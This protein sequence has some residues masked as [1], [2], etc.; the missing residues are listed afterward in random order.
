MSGGSRK[1]FKPKNRDEAMLESVGIDRLAN[2]VIPIASTAA[3][4]TARRDEPVGALLQAVPG[5]IANKSVPISEG[6]GCVTKLQSGA[7][8]APVAVSVDGTRQGGDG[9]VFNPAAQLMGC[10]SDGVAAKVSDIAGKFATLSDAYLKAAGSVEKKVVDA[11]PGSR[12]NPINLWGGTGDGIMST[13][14]LAEYICTEMACPTTEKAYRA[15]AA[16][17]PCHGGNT[18]FHKMPIVAGRDVVFGFEGKL[19]AVRVCA[20]SWR[21]D[22]SCGFDPTSYQGMHAASFEWGGAFVGDRV[23]LMWESKFERGM[24]VNF[25]ACPMVSQ[26]KASETE[27]E[28][29]GQPFVFDQEEAGRQSTDHTFEGVVV[30]AFL[31]DGTSKWSHVNDRCKKLLDHRQ[32]LVKD[33]REGRDF[34]EG[35]V[36]GLSMD[37]FITDPHCIDEEVLLCALLAVVALGRE[38]SEALEK[39]A[40]PPS[41]KAASKRSTNVSKPVLPFVQLKAADVVAVVRRSRV[42]PRTCSCNAL[43]CPSASN[44][45]YALVVNR[46]WG[47]DGRPSR[48]LYVVSGLAAAIEKIGQRC[49][50]LDS[51]SGCSFGTRAERGPNVSEVL[52]LPGSKDTA[53]I[54]GN[55]SRVEVVVVEDSAVFE[56]DIRAGDRYSCLCERLREECRKGRPMTGKLGAKFELLPFFI[57]AIILYWDGFNHDQDTCASAEGVYFLPQSFPSTMRATYVCIRILGLGPS[58]SNIVHTIKVVLDEVLNLVEH[59]LLVRLPDG[60]KMMVFVLLTGCVADSPALSSA[61]DGGGHSSLSP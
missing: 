8:A 51:A 7:E 12:A 32:K 43:G 49:Q 34:V 53:S 30:A 47:D 10:S 52:E 60:T 61:L 57:Y 37:N 2:G 38:E 36:V 22:L 42:C 56:E 4:V 29:N 16:N 31:V 15:T 6:D 23:S 48:F 18:A 40:L 41:G 11:E 9:V 33:A 28:R 46:T 50:A 35:G 3:N 26:T 17:G 27:S 39:S 5:G 55:R 1:S 58:G 44:S 45:V 13:I 59:E 24:A 14:P 20:E 25:E 54:R 19:D 21:C